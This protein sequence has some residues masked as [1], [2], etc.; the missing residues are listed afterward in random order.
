M[1]TLR[2][3]P[4][5]A[6]V[7]GALLNRSQ[8]QA[9]WGASGQESITAEDFRSL[10][11][12]SG[13]DKKNWKRLVALMD[14]TRENERRLQDA[15]RRRQEAPASP[16]G[17]PSGSAL[18]GLLSR[19]GGRAESEA[20]PLPQ[21]LPVPPK[22]AARLSEEEELLRKN[23]QTFVNSRVLSPEI[24]TWVAQ[25]LWTA[26]RHPGGSEVVKD[27]VSYLRQGLASKGGPLP[28]VE[29]GPM[30]DANTYGLYTSGIRKIELRAGM[31][32]PLFAAVLD[33]ELLHSLDDTQDQRDKGGTPISQNWH[34]D[35]GDNIFSG[36]DRQARDEEKPNPEGKPEGA[37]GAPPEKEAEEAPSK[38]PKSQAFDAEFAETMAWRGMACAAEVPAII[39]EIQR[40]N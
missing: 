24:R 30:P 23:I 13:N 28:T 19:A 29:L 14:E 12:L 40:C 18:Q 22:N 8:A 11:K 15:A 2:F 33:H 31:P 36:Q 38:D 3:I 34:R 20:P 5:I 10:S 6:V 35:R 1:N 37:E 26:A 4:L 16:R 17:A 21:A 9:G 39:P 7:T 25:Y 27:H 32:W